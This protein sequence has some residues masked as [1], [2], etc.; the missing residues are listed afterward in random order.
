MLGWENSTVNKTGKHDDIQ[1]LSIRI[2][3][4]L[5]GYH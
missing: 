1:D 2:I 5:S 3:S 4:S